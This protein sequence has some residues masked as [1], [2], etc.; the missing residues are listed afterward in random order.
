[1]PTVRWLIF[2]REMSLSRKPVNH[3]LTVRYSRN[4]VQNVVWLVIT[5]ERAA[6]EGVNIEQIPNAFIW[7]HCSLIHVTSPPVVFVSLINGKLD[8]VLY[9]SHSRCFKGA[10][11]TSRPLIR[12]G[13]CRSLAIVSQLFSNFVWLLKNK[14]VN[15]Y[16]R[17]CICQQNYFILPQLKVTNWC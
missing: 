9:Q 5:T 2:N 11:V 8:T 4:K 15:S 16:V 17:W 10:L 3:K 12:V 7:G 13:Y 1:M 14:V 6:R